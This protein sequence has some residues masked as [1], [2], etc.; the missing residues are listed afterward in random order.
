MS[1]RGLAGHSGFTLA[2][3]MV[4]MAI[5]AV[6]LVATSAALQYGLS[7]IETGRGESAAVFLVEQKLEELKGI[8]LVAWSDTALQPGTTTEYCHTSGGDCSATMTAGSL[9]RTTTVTQGTGGVCT[10]ACKMVSV[11]VLYRPLTA[12]GQLDQ[13]RRVDIR[14]MFVSRT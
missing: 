13:E 4:A 2:E 14:A 7:G 11:S 6:G 10:A 8:A 5:V 1:G 9:R 12:L 3:V